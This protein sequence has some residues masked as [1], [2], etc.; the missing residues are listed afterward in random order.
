MEGY[1]TVRTSVI[2]VAVDNRI[3]AYSSLEDLPVELRER[4]IESTSG[5][6]A[7]TILIADRKGRDA[8]LRSLRKRLLARRRRGVPASA[9]P[10]QIPGGWLRTWGAI[11]LSGAAGLAVWLVATWR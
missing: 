11:L 8:M 7:A 5:D 10:R 6:Y 1:R 4:L 3:E 9:S 2:L